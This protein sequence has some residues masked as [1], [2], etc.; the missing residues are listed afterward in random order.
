MSTAALV[1]AFTAGLLLYGRR[2]M[3]YVRDL[4]SNKRQLELMRLETIKQQ[5]V[6]ERH[7][8]RMISVSMMV[9]ERLLRVRQ[10]YSAAQAVEAVAVRCTQLG[11]LQE[12]RKIAIEAVRILSLHFDNVTESPFFDDDEL[13]DA[14]GLS[15]YF[16]L[17]L[18]DGSFFYDHVYRVAILALLTLGSSG[19]VSNLAPI[20][21]VEDWHRELAHIV[22]DALLHW[23]GSE[24]FGSEAS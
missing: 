21:D 18:V 6:H 1:A 5:E 22:A 19:S 10:D 8:Q 12:C 23:K 11:I 4:A 7:Q 20:D 17:H 15:E 9:N 2:A 16:A 24:W 14:K 13:D 3:L